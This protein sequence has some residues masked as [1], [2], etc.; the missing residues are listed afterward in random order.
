MGGAVI[1]RLAVGRAWRM[2]VIWVADAGPPALVTVT[3]EAA[4]V[5]IEVPGP[6]RPALE[7]PRELHLHFHGADPAEAAAILRQ[8]AGLR[9]DVRDYPLADP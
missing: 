4:P 6:H 2:P 9:P 1:W 5:A 8:A 3:A 7:Q